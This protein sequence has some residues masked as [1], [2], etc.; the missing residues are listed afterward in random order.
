MSLLVYFF[1]ILTEVMPK[2]VEIIRWKKFYSINTRGQCYKT[3]LHKYANVG[4]T[5]QEI[6]QELCKLQWKKVYNIVTW[7]VNQI[8]LYWPKF[9]HTF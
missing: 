4:V 3:F 2:V 9:T 8:K 7:G 1:K 5:L 6:R